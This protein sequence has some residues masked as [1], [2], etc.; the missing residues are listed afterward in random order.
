MPGISKRKKS[1]INLHRSP[2]SRRKI[3]V[4]LFAGAGGLDLGFEQ[5]GFDVR[6]AL[7]WDARSCETLRHNR[8]HKAVI[9]KDI[10]LVTPEEILSAG[11]IKPGN[12]FAVI[13]GPPCQGFSQIGKRNPKD[14]RNFLFRE[15]LRIVEGLRPAVFL[16]ENTEAITFARNREIFLSILEAGMKIGYAVGYARLCAT[17]FGVPQRRRRCF[18]FGRRLPDFTQFMLPPTTVRDAIEALMNVEV[19]TNGL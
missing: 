2:S 15:Y 18:I 16:M 19:R 9:Q 6:V 3:A 10:A 5:A 7:E 13:G 4:S 14:P 8:P 1:H 12:V 11:K 17:D